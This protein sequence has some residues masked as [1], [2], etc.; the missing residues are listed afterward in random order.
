M[1]LKIFETKD[2]FKTHA[3]IKGVF[4]KSCRGKIELI[5]EIRIQLRIELNKFKD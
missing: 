2:Q 4:S 1:K 5:L 3:K